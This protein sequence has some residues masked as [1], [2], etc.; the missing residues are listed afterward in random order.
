MI[1]ITPDI[2][3]EDNEIQLDFIHSSGPGGQNVNKVATAVK[4]YF[5]I[6]NSP[7]LPEDIKKRLTAFGGK[8]VT[9]DGILV[10]D[11]RRYRTQ[12][13]NRQD[14]IERL[15][16]LIGKAAKKPKKRK[17]TRPTEASRE[18]RLKLKHSQ[19]EKKVLR[20]AV[21]PFAD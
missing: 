20:K 7:S 10:I 5:D 8:R 9:Q 4:L 21:D 12:E 16:S 15:S 19:G 1:H 18:K 6:I 14:A 17:K 3:L 11:A 13:R 2:S